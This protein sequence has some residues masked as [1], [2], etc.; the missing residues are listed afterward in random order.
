MALATGCRG[1]TAEGLLEQIQ[2][3]KRSAPLYIILHNIEGTTGAARGSSSDLKLL[4]ESDTVCHSLQ[5]S[6][7]A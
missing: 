4:W 6:A 3:D 1:Y 7:C 5:R 2:T